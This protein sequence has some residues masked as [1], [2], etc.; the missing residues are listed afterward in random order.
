M[1]VLSAFIKLKLAMTYKKTPMSCIL[2]PTNPGMKRD[3]SISHTEATNR[4]YPSIGYD[5]KNDRWSHPGVMP[6]MEVKIEL[7]AECGWTLTGIAEQLPSE[8][9][10][11]VDPNLQ[12]SAR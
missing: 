6:L 8:S 9:L 4:P 10:G 5:K 12:G 1:G 11:V 2:N 3:H 7:C